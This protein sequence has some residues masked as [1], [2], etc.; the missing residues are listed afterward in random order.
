MFDSN[1]MHIIAVGAATVAAE[2]AWDLGKD[3]FV[4]FGAKKLGINQDQA[5]AQVI[6]EARGV[7][8][9][10]EDEIPQQQCNGVPQ[11]PIVQQVSQQQVPPQ[12][13]PQQGMPYIMPGQMVP[14]QGMP[15][16]GMP[17]PQQPM[18]PITFQQQ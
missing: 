14:P 10:E 5:L 11:Q 16:Q 2:E 7:T 15:Q 13:M 17:Y 4:G 8:F 6:L 1:A 12:M 18:S 9:D 3:L